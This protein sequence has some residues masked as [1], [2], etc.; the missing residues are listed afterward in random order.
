MEVSSP[1]VQ[2]L[3]DVCLLLLWNATAVCVLCLSAAMGGGGR[4][5]FIN[6]LDLW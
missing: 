6:R 2:F 4:M 3:Q 1:L 5:S